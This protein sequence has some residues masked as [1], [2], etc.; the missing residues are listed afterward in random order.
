MAFQ[1]DELQ[2]RV[3]Q[4]DAYLVHGVTLTVGRVGL[5]C[6]FDFDSAWDGLGKGCVIKS[7][8]TEVQATIVNNC[9]TIPSARLVQGKNLIIGVYGTNGST[10]VIPTI[11]CSLGMVYAAASAPTIE[12][13]TQ[14][15]ALQVLGYMNAALGSDIHGID[16]DASDIGD[17]GTPSMTMNIVDSGSPLTCTKTGDGTTKNF[18]AKVDGV[19]FT[20]CSDVSVDGTSKSLGTDYT[21]NVSSGVVTFATAPAVN[22]AI[23]ITGTSNKKIIEV[24]VSNLRGRGIKSGAFNQQRNLVFT[25]DDD[26]TLVITAIDTALD[27][28][29][30]LETSITASESARVTAETNRASAETSRATAESGRSTAET[31]RVTAETARASAE[32]SRATAETSRSTA[33][34]SRATAETTR[35]DSEQTRINNEY[36]RVSTENT[37]A[38]HEQ[39]RV[40]AETARASAESDR[41]SSENMRESAESSRASAE[42]SRASAESTRV[43]NET[44]RGTAESNRATAETN[45]S[46]AEQSRAS[47][48]Q[49]RTSSESARVAS[50]SSRA[51]AETSR[52]NAETGRVSAETARVTAESAR[53]TEFASMKARADTYVANEVVFI[54]GTTVYENEILYM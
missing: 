26:T 22:A 10:V 5:K 25:Y 45:R 41:A 8:G 43:S 40:S 16:L 49:Q 2:V 1:Y 52:A 33:E 3:S 11:W 32:T 31:N 19:A 50:E 54:Y 20:T 46:N 35:Q 18:E 29:E 47:A 42:S 34:T 27:S 30:A 39:S 13:V 37:R 36:D 21:F 4:A 38:S 14:S 53:V 15:F 9:V 17:Y 44:A 51:S 7:N 6:E 48:E 28:I 23:T 24:E 12:E